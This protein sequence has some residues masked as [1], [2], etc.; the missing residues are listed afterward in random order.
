MCGKR[1]RQLRL[2]FPPAAQASG[3]G[4]VV[5]PPSTLSS[6]EWLLGL[7]LLGLTVALSGGIY[8]WALRY[9]CIGCIQPIAVP[10]DPEL[11]ERIV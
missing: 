6:P 10:K 5:T 3:G 7:L 11:W 8:L 4:L 9:V 1:C 2:F